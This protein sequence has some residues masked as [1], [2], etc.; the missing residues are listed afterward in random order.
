[1]NIVVG[2]LS[3]VCR[4][5]FLRNW[6]CTD[7]ASCAE[8]LLVNVEIYVRYEDSDSCGDDFAKVVD[9]NVMRD[10][11]LEAGNPSASTFIDRALCALLRAPIVLASI[12]VVNSR[13]GTAVS[14]SRPGDARTLQ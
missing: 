2:E 12:E 4:R 1:M 3:I 10:S 13:S 7:T 14:E 8:W 6:R 11:L 5:L 9:Y